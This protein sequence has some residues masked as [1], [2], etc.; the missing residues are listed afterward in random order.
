[1]RGGKRVIMYATA[2]T[3]ITTA[4]KITGPDSYD[5]VYGKMPVSRQRCNSEQIS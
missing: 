3:T 5:P 2:A 4:T 1:M